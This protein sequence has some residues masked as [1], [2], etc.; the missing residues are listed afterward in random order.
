MGQGRTPE[1]DDVPDGISGDPFRR[2]LCRPSRPGAARADF[3]NN[4]VA[5]HNGIFNI[6]MGYCLSNYFCI[7]T[8]I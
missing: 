5:Q 8:I 2:L 1:P 7:N 4:I 6:L 3:Y